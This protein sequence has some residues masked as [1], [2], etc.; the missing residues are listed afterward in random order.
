MRAAIDAA[1]ACNA[2]ALELRVLLA[3]ID[4]VASWSR[5]WDWIGTRRLAA[6]VYGVDYDK[7]SGWQRR[8]VVT[9]LRELDAMG[10]LVYESGGV[11]RASRPRIALGRGVGPHP[12]VE[13]EGV[14]ADTP[15]SCS[16]EPEGDRAQHG[17]GLGS[18]QKGCQIAATIEKE[19]EDVVRDARTRARAHEDGAAAS[20]RRLTD[21]APIVR[22]P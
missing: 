11:G 4:L 2:G 6:R 19:F 3:V 22:G 5:R 16:G 15:S 10:A 18:A 12:L 13:R 21:L 14:S 20:P 8:N 1:I 7:V 9:A 17:R